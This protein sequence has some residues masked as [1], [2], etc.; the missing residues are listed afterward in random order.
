[1]YRIAYCNLMNIGDLLNEY[2]LDKIGTNYRLI[3]HKIDQPYYLFIGSLVQP[4]YCNSFAI[5]CGSGYFLENESVTI[6]EIKYVRGKLTRKKLIEMGYMCPE[7]YGDPGLIISTLYSQKSRS[8]PMI[9]YTPHVSD[10]AYYDENNIPG[11]IYLSTYDIESVLDQIANTTYLV[12]SS[13]HGIII[14]HSYGK[15]A[16]WVNLWD[17]GILHNDSIKFHDY[18][19]SLDLSVTPYD[20]RQFFLLNDEEK[21]DLIEKYPN[22]DTATIHRLIDVIM[23]NTP[24]FSSKILQKI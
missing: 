4:T 5:I 2:I 3:T 1:M 8:M 18:Y 14:A 9:C 19:S 22:P 16:I 11:T 7:L 21:I 24:F 6:G 20:I 13:L 17:N 15:K 12:S 10:N 23:N